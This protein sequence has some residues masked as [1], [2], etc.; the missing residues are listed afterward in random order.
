MTDFLMDYEKAKKMVNEN[1]WDGFFEHFNK[2]YE[3]YNFYSCSQWWYEDKKYICKFR[4]GSGDL[5]V[6]WKGVHDK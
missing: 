5:I 4:G 2:E 1:G 3:D 6:G